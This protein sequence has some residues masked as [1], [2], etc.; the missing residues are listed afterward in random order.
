MFILLSVVVVVISV[1]LILIVLIQNPKGGVLSS[2]FSSMGNQILGASRSTE[3]VEKFTWY[4]AGALMIICV[5]SVFILPSTEE[6]QTENTQKSVLQEELS[7]SK[8]G[9]IAAP[10]TPATPVVPST[11]TPTPA[12]PTPDDKVKK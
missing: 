8:P 2:S 7:K 10:S 12:S 3:T 11:S 9:S 1:L 5:A 6:T 4:L